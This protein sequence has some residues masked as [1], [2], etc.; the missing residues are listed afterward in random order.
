[1]LLLLEAYPYCG[2]AIRH[3]G[4]KVRVAPRLKGCQR[5]YVH[6]HILHTQL[7]PHQVTCNLAHVNYAT[8]TQ[9][10]LLRNVAKLEKGIFI[11]TEE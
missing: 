1:M 9:G 5:F 3:V 4:L 6:A 11:N 2:D 7:S 10:L 8:K